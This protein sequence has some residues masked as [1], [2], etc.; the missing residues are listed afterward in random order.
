MG[1]PRRRQGRILFLQQRR[2][3]CNPS[4]ELVGFSPHAVVVRARA[5]KL[6]DW[7][8]TA[9][10]ARHLRE[11]VLAETAGRRSSAAE[12]AVPAEAWTRLMPS[13]APSGQP[14]GV[15][16]AGEPTRPARAH[17]GCGGEWRMLCR[18]RVGSASGVPRPG[19]THARASTPRAGAK[20]PHWVWPAAS[21]PLEPQCR[22]QPR[23]HR[24]QGRQRA[25]ARIFHRQGSAGPCACRRV[26]R[27]GFQALVWR[28]G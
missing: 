9:A 12:K 11:A 28:G 19:R 8:G 7:A 21:A 24:R 10:P 3:A 20:A 2:A 1:A 4:F 17:A 27:S 13:P 5:Q 18:P 25:R 22:G 26:E 6:R 23:M 14:A 16:K 15:R